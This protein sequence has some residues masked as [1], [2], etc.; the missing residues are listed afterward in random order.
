MN[1]DNIRGTVSGRYKERKERKAA[2]IVPKESTPSAPRTFLKIYLVI[3][4]AILI[5]DIR[6][7]FNFSSLDNSQAVRCPSEYTSSLTNLTFLQL[8]FGTVLEKL[9]QDKNTT[10]Q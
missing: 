8:D 2:G 9:F 5:S 6:T 3:K 4:P 7:Q 10:L 1:T